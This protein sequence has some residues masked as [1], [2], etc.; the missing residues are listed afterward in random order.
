VQS[1][2]TLHRLPESGLVLGEKREKKGKKT[3]AKSQDG[4]KQYLEVASFI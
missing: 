4:L 1:F 2:K 3:G